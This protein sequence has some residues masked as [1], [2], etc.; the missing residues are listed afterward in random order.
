[1]AESIQ[2]ILDHINSAV[3]WYPLRDKIIEVAPSVFA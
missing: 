1:M 3:D 2:E